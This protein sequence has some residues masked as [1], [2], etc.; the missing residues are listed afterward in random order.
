MSESKEGP[1]YW[2]S[3]NTSRGRVRMGLE[4]KE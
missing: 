3:T 2:N 1:S 4:A